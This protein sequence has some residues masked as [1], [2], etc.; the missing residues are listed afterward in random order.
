MTLRY[1][2][3]DPE[4]L[5]RS[6]AWLAQRGAHPY[7]LVNDWELPRFVERFG[8]QQTTALVQLPPLFEYRNSATIYCFDLL[9]RAMSPRRIQLSDVNV[10][11]RS[12]RPEPA[13][14]LVLQ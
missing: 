3:L 5:D 7:L 8:S 9:P 12:V 1:D 11:L 10:D 4:W 13:P 6:V 2:Q 14:S